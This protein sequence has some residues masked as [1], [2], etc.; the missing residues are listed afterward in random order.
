MVP[1]ILVCDDQEML[2]EL[3]AGAIWATHPDAEV[4]LVGNGREAERLLSEDRF[5][6]VFLDV[7][8]PIQDGLT[9]LSN[10]RERNLAPHTAFVLCTG[11]CRDL[12]I[13]RGKCSQADEYL[14]KPIDIVT[15]GKVVEQ[16]AAVVA[17]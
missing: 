12:D 4:V 3:M 10:I 17:V 11:H 5:D 7:E 9:T 6:L 1:K 2:R 13:V 8:M 15:V 16:F 14:T